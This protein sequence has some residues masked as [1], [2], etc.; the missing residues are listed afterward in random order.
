MVSPRLDL[1]LDGPPGLRQQAL[2]PAN[3]PAPFPCGASEGLAI[4]S[5][6]SA[7][8]V[9]RPPVTSVSY[10]GSAGV[11]CGDLGPGG[12]CGEM[13]RGTTEDWERLQR[14]NDAVADVV[15]STGNAG[16]PVYLDLEDDVLT[17]I[18]D[19]AEPSATS[20]TVG[21]VRAVLAVMPINQGPS[22]ILKPF[23]QQL[24]RWERGSLDDAPPTLALLAVLSL[25]AE[26][27]RDG[28]GKAANNFYGRLAELFGLDEQQKTR[29]INAYRMVRDDRA[30][31]EILWGSLNLWLELHEGNRGLPTAFADR[32]AH[33]GLP[34]SQA[35]VREVDRE[36]FKSMFATY[37]FAPGT[38]LPTAEMAE[39]IH[40]WMSHVPC[41]ASNQ[42][43]RSWKRDA[44]ARDRI[45]DVAQAALES[46]DGSG[47]MIADRGDRAVDQLRVRAAVRTF[48]R[49]RLDLNLLLPMTPGADRVVME[50]VDADNSQLG[51]VEMVSHTSGWMWMAEPA[52]IDAGSILR[53]ETRMRRTGDEAL[54]RRRPRRV[55]PLR[56]DALSSGCVECERVNL[57]DDFVLL[58]HE[59]LGSS[60]ER[61][62][63]ASG[64]PGYERHDDLAGLPAGWVLFDHV[65]IVSSAPAELVK[66]VDL[67]PLL[68]LTS[69]QAVL[70]GGLALPGNIKKWSSFSPPELRVSVGEGCSPAA[71][72][73]SV[74]PLTSPT[75]QPVSM[76][77]D[78]PVLL[79]DLAGA[80]LPDGDYDVV[81]DVDGTPMGR[82]LRLR[83]R[84]AAHPAVIS[85]ADEFHLSHHASHPTFGLH[86]SSGASPGG[87]QIAPAGG[88]GF[89]SEPAGQLVPGWVVARTEPR[90][91]TTGAGAIRIPSPAAGSCMLTGAHLM[92]LPT[93]YP[94]KPTEKLIDGV[95]ANCGLTK[96]FPTRGRQKRASRTPERTVPFFDPRKLQPVRAHAGTAD[97]RIGLDSLSHLRQGSISAL[98]RI[99][100]HVDASGLF[101]D[102]FTRRLEELG[103]IEVERDAHSLK[104][105]SWAMCLPSL[106]ELADGRWAIVGFRSESI[107][108][109]VEDAAYE[110][111]VDYITDESVQG[112]P[113]ITVDGAPASVLKNVVAAMGTATNRTSRFIPSAASALASALPP[114]SKALLSLP[115]T[116]LVHG[117]SIERW[118]PAVARFRSV[119]GANEVGA[120][121]ISG[122]G[123]SYVYRWAQ[124]LETMSGR[125]GDARIVKYAAALDSGLPLTGYEPGSQILYVPLGADLP[126][127]Y[128]R[129]AV[130]A[131]GRPPVA[132]DKDRVL[133]YSGVPPALAS[134]IH[135][136]L[137][138]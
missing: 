7:T 61:V 125:I 16:Q 127:L 33:V 107:I 116:S 115:T 14:W 99:A 22:L 1:R 39:V 31:S 122:F 32:H 71:T 23:E 132:D 104:P 66:H 67:N 79:W 75:P 111:G 89:E 118:D 4:G 93:A 80:H 131:S 129:A 37:G 27:M 34:M 128:G 63:G 44:D 36:K 30:V 55:V 58:V 11:S 72:I 20:A 101:A 130:L 69:S 83:L 84:S 59:E 70:Q 28:D 86:P 48:P 38:T 5:N 95:C 8:L 24:W 90:S 103:H 117:R 137:M 62:L 56:F 98:E 60:V 26:K 113:L 45:A 15:Y 97:W 17:K 135:T 35:L 108:A 100:A 96:R 120:Y 21:L 42:L 102:T 82:P 65:Q 121:R 6:G 78:D 134:Q 133:R 105:V 119:S 43:E 46:W 52:G 25:A 73:S 77:S 54:L 109:A 112:P 18:R 9:R 40:D 76:Q 47:G 91:Q 81:I 114:L 88:P 123:R 68:P 106:V 126:G 49:R 29:F 41:P 87:F 124:D 19:E 3:H 2:R 10:R 85:E 50:V 57:G 94:G 74:R 64:R 51:E 92:K 13:M 53:G 110:A 136:L 138:S 12:C